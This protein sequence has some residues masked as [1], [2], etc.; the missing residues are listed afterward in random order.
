MSSYPN[1][2]LGTTDWERRVA[3]AVNHLLNRLNYNHW[4]FDGQPTAGEVLILT[5]FPIATTLVA[6][7]CGGWV[8]ATSVATSDA[9]VSFYTDGVLVGTVT[10]P[11]GQQ[12]A[13]V[14]ITN[15]LIPADTDFQIVAPDPQDATLSDFTLILAT[16]N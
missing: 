3:M 10:Y 4:V 12:T 1:V 15:P 6:G 8:P 14:S 9:V 13:V 5:Q 11:A 2:P 7:S 16:S